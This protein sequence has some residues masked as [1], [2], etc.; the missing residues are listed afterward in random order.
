MKLHFTQK[1]ICGH[2]GPL[3]WAHWYEVRSGLRGRGIARPV[4]S[5][6]RYNTLMII[7]EDDPSKGYSAPL[8]CC[9]CLDPSCGVTIVRDI[10]DE[11]TITVGHKEE[12]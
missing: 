12:M 4:F 5:E 10:T 2:Y 8:D 7:Y 1:A 9:L 3:A 6:G 11:V